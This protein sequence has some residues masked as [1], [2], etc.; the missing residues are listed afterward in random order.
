MPT[1]RCGASE[2]SC[3]FLTI[4]PTGRLLFVVDEL[5]CSNRP[6]T[7]E[8]CGAFSSSTQKKKKGEITEVSERGGGARLWGRSEYKCDRG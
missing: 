7:L 5:R 4:L 6:T 8:H 3:L 1:L 2:A